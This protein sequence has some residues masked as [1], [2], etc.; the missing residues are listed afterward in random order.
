[1][2]ATHRYLLLLFAAVVAAIAAGGSGPAKDAVR[3]TAPATV[4]APKAPA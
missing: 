3:T 4:E 1:M 2:N